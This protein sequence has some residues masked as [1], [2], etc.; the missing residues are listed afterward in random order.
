MAPIV[1]CLWWMLRWPWLDDSHKESGLGPCASRPPRRRSAG[2][3]APID[4]WGERLWHVPEC[5]NKSGLAAFDAVD[6]ESRAHKR[7]AE[8]FTFWRKHNQRCRHNYCIRGW[9]AAIT[10]RLTLRA[11]ICLLLRRQGWAVVT[12]CRCDANYLSFR[13]MRIERLISEKTC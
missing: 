12:S 1:A 8:G 3:A 11:P 7:K 13:A 5:L 9:T 10:I 2:T 4:G 6:W